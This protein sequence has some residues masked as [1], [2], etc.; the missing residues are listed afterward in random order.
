MQSNMNFFSDALVRLKHSLRVSK[1]QE[2]AGFLGLSKT[3]FAE[4]KRRGSFP[5]AELQA[6]C[7][8][9][10]ELR[11]NFTHIME[12]DPAPEE[13]YDEFEGRF[14]RTQHMA[15]IVNALPLPELRKNKITIL[16]TG[17]ALRDAA[18]IAA[19]LQREPVLAPDEQML[20]DTYRRCT[21]EAKAN[22]IQTAALL[23]VGMAAAVNSPKRRDTKQ[24][25]GTHTAQQN[26]HAPV[27][28]DVVGRDKIVPSPTST[29]EKTRNEKL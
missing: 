25:A 27:Q 10:P 28:G 18:L 20:V 24:D 26:F 8:A 12:G 17:D 7:E 1:D 19:D 9:R 23:S 14:A 11:L 16:L 13:S 22:L 15:A 4:R 3:A 6:L 29:R 5:E 21:R 2:V